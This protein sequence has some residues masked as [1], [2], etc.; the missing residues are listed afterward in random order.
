M[1]ITYTLGREFASELRPIVERYDGQAVADYLQ[2]YWPAPRL[3]ELLSCGHD[4]AVKIALLGLSLIGTTRDNRAIAR[5]LHDDDAFTA[6]MAEH[7]LWS[8]WFRGGDHEANRTLKRAVH[9]LSRDRL[10][11]AISILN[12]LT[13]RCPRFAEV[14]NQ[15]AIA[16]FLKGNH[17]EA[18]ENCHC[19]L[20]L[21]PYHFGAMAGLGH[22]C[23][24]LGKLDLALE[25]YHDALH[26]NPRM[27]G[28]RQS[29]QEV[30]ARCRR[31]H[32]PPTNPLP[33]PASEQQSSPFQ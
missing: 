15:L 1:G 3:V 26:L 4:E 20:E 8:T 5:L 11:D 10:D 16:H 14:F 32:A 27:Q 31:Q 28:I 25:A 29:I 7:A 30:R 23:A 2:Q 24:S 21:N 19:T 17:A 6:A 13:R 12:D 9:L 33:K 18:I 22:C